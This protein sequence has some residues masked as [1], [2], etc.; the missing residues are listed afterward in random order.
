[1]LLALTPA[2]RVL[3]LQH[4]DVRFMTKVTNNY[5]FTFGILHKA[6]R[7]RTIKTIMVIKM[8]YI[9]DI[10]NDN[11]KLKKKKNCSYINE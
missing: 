6:W 8:A 9:M 5:M 3:G 10:H 11:I 1:M 2:S 7:K 4:L